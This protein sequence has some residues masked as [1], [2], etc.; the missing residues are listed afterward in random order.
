M[1]KKLFILFVITLY[2]LSITAQNIKDVLKK[3]N[4]QSIPYTY[5]NK[6]SK[7]KQVLFLDAREQAEF[8]VSK[9]P[10]A[11]FVGHNNFSEADVLKKLPNK[12]QHIVVYCSIGVRSEKIASRLK[13]LG[14]TKV[15]NLWGGIFEWKNQGN[16]IVDNTNIATENVHCFSKEW[17]QYV[18][19]GNKIY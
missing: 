3:Y 14:Y 12:N 8:E 9:I 1:P 10:N 17:A 5:C 7:L 16:K 13:L 15:Y 11:I 19:V 4:T 18:K 2:S 6:A